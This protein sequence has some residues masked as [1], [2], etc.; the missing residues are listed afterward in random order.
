[1]NIRMSTTLRSDIFESTREAFRRGWVI[2]A[3][4]LAEEIRLRNVGENVALEDIESSVMAAAQQ[5]GAMIEFGSSVAMRV[6]TSRAGEGLDDKTL[7]IPQR[8]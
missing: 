1:M 8:D 5:L 6:P 3:S 4:V 7:H 2:N